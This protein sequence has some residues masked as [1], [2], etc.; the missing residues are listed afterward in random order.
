MIRAVAVLLTA[1]LVVPLTASAANPVRI[2]I[3]KRVCTLG[4]KADCQGVKARWVVKFHGSLRGADLR[5]A[6]L[7]GADL[8]GADLRGADL[9]GAKLHHADLRRANLAGVQAGPKPGAGRRDR[10]GAPCGASCQGAVLIDVNMM[11]A[12]LTGANFTDAVLEESDLQYATLTSAIFDG[13]DMYGIRANKV[14]AIGTSFKVSASGTAVDLEYGSLVSGN[15][16]NAIITGANLKLADL[17]GANLSGTN[18]TGSDLT[19]ADLQSATHSGWITT[20]VTWSQTTCPS[21]N[22]TNTGC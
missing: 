6:D 21:G 8:R 19:L 20:G 5:G 4:P 16:S 10:A 18:L 22:V 15:F 11:G 2:G 14:V 12:N 17:A 13:A 7:M 9:R 3:G 1:L